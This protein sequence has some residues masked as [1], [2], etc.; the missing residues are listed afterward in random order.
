MG[1]GSGALAGAPSCTKIEA[2]LPLSEKPIQIKKDVREGGIGR[3]QFII[4][5]AGKLVDVYEVEKKKLG[6]GS[7]GD[8]FRVTNKST[9][10]VRAVK[11]IA[12][13]QMKNIERFKQEIAIMKIMDHP[14]IIKLYETFEDNRN[15]YLVMELCKGGEL[16]DRIISAGRFSEV[17]AATI[18]QQIVRAIYYMHENHI[19]HR[20]LKPENFLFATKDSIEK[21]IL[22]TIDFGLSCKFEEGQVLTTKA[23]TPYYVA[24]QVLCGKYDQRCDMWSCGVI[25]HVILCGYP[26]FCGE[27]DGEVLQRVRL[28]VFSF[29]ASDWKNVSEDAKDLIRQLLKMNPKDR[30]TA[31][32]ALNHAWIKNKA[33]KALQVNLHEGFVDNLRAFLCQNKLKKA[34]LHI[35]ANQLNEDQIKA[36]RETFMSLD[37]NGD[38][39]LTVN[40]LKE[41]IVKA[42]LKEI[43]QDL[44]AIMDEVD[45]DGS[46][47]IDYT[48]FL[49]ATLDR[50]IYLKEDVVWSAFRVFDRN[51]DGRISQEELAQVL[52]DGCVQDMCGVNA[53]HSLLESVDTDGDGTIDFS[54]FMNMMRMKGS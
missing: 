41:G 9:R 38:G 49:A 47:V 6:E 20:D 18:M 46:G 37:H 30:Y 29:K 42:G 23:G 32:Q 21:G 52:A 25:M 34:A 33:P 4:D 45:S 40:E 13:A 3:A 54:E 48:E 51:G 35:I 10:A 27:T 1:C 11:S 7:Y 44:Q 28:G 43:P 8:V 12:K 16:F 31:E 53:V 50:R 15:I 36:L 24:P 2:P 14:N 22:K 17:K 5:N 39:Q 19:C 26:P